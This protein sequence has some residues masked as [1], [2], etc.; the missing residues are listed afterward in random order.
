MRSSPEQPAPAL[1]PP[2]IDIAEIR[3][4]ISFL[5]LSPGK[6]APPPPAP[7]PLSPSEMARETSLRSN[8]AKIEA[9]FGGN[10]PRLWLCDDM[11]QLVFQLKSACRFAEAESLMR[12]TLAC[13]EAQFEAEML[14]YRS[15][16]PMPEKAARSF[17]LL[18]FH[19][20]CSSP[21]TRLALLLQATNQFAEAELLLRRALAVS[22]ELCGNDY[23]GIAEDIN[24][25]ARLLQAAGHPMEAE[26]LMRRALA[27]D[28]AGGTKWEVATDL[29]HLAQ[30]LQA[31]NRSTQAEPLIRRALVLDDAESDPMHSA[32]ARDLNCL[33][34][35][36]RTT[37]RLAEA[38]PVMRQALEISTWYS[39][40][41]LVDRPPLQEWVASYRQIL[42]EL[43]TPDTDS[44]ERIANILA[45]PRPP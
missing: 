18:A 7:I 32:V 16:F 21:L 17:A 6:T 19:P 42:K 27:L 10:S 29:I 9:Q 14:R 30:V 8:L 39:R 31:T 37:S 23:S 11:T 20:P 25:L 38:E 36:L 26:P 5:D 33:A 22:E 1:G 15:T 2:R 45:P 13:A 40:Q 41:N 44:E 28:E 3:C 12:R 43:G 4:V 24:N 35:S 34:Q